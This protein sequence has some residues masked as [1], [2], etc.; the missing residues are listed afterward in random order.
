MREQVRAAGGVLWRER[1]GII[2]FAVVH[3]PKYD[4]W[5]LPKGKLTDGESYLEAALRE[6][7]EE[8]GFA[9]EVGE[10]LGTVS[11][12]SKSRP[13]VV[14]YWAM[15]AGEGG[16]VAHSE[17]DDLRWLSPEAAMRQ[18]SYDRDREVLQRFTRRPV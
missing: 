12:L 6:V 15:R 18:L 5:S 3:R 2:E 1:D 14:Q 13:K 10:D 8:T 17:V 7:R 11:Y 4:D 16:F 9:A